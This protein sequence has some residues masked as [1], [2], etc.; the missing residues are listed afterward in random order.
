M[1]LFVD[2]SDD[3]D[4]SLLINV[5][6]ITSMQAERGGTYIHTTHQASTGIR[7]RLTPWQIMSRIESVR[8]AQ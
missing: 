5:D 4:K 1:A 6:N 3:D 8:R 2:L 7:V